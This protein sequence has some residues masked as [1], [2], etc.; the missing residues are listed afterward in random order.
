MS[1]LRR[2]VFALC[3]APLAL[4]LAACG[5]GDDEGALPSGEA[6]AP[7]AAPA[8]Q[9]WTD[10][11]AI[12]P[13]G[14]WLAGNPEAPIKLVEYGSV[15][16]PAC[17]A[18]S[19][20]GMQ[21]LRE[22]YVNSGR[23][24]Y[25]FRSVAIHG[26]VDLVLTRLLECVPKEAVHPLNEQLWANNAAVLGPVQANAAA[27]EQAM[28]LPEN[29]RFI[30]FADLGGLLDFVAARGISRDQASQCLA[31]AAAIKALA[32]RMEAQSEKD[33]VTGTPTFFVNGARV[34]EIHWAPVEAALQRAGAR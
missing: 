16:C 1:S 32:E 9:Q 3:A 31:D 25:E 5:S 15:T 20:E 7:V 26:A 8:G 33:Q 13:E 24:N 10:I 34:D 30:A 19:V 11:V 12:T 22:D 2:L 17:A 28:G 21:Q 18:F 23:V 27:I 4:G 14:G 29:Q 6:V